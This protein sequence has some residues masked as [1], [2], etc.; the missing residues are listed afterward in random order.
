MDVS[1]LVAPFIGTLKDDVAVGVDVVVGLNTG[2][3]EVD[4]ITTCG[5]FLVTMIVV[6]VGAVATAGVRI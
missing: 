5:V 2:G 3:A 6:V 4:P 1:P